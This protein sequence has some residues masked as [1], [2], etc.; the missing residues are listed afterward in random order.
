[1]RHENVSLPAGRQ[2]SGLSSSI[3]ERFHYSGLNKA[4]R[5]HAASKTKFL[6]GWFWAMP[7]LRVPLP[8]VG[9]GEIWGHRTC[10]YSFFG[11]VPAFFG[12]KIRP[13]KGKK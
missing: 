3:D 5:T 12:L 2:E 9:Q 10:F 7:P 6:S 1:L 8:G 4:L 13:G 11:S